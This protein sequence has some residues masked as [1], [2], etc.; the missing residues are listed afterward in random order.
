M[1]AKV[2]RQL[3]AAWRSDPAAVAVLYELSRIGPVRISALA[4]T[5]A[6][7]V[8]TTSRH[9]RALEVDEL[10]E[11]QADDADG[12]ATLLRISEAG[13]ELLTDAIAERSAILRA[14]TVDWSDDDLAAL[15]DYLVRLADDI[16]VVAEKQ[17]AQ[18]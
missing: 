8:S 1:L 6:L 5:L 3:R 13:R 17:S 16:A 18:A 4:N 7:D 14:A 12:R 11:R 2:G 9:V 10:I 15:N